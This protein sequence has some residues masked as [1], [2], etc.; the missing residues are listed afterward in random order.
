MTVSGVSDWNPGS[1]GSAFSGDGAEGVRL[2]RLA[3]DLDF[4]PGFYRKNRERVNVK[5][6]R[7]GGEA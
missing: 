3:P 5:K 6:R 7:A 1:T 2:F 4:M